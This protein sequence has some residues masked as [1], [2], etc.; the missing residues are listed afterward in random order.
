MVKHIRMLPTVD[1]LEGLML[2]G[3]VSKIGFTG[4]LSVGKPKISD[5]QYMDMVK[6]AVA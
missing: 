3:A 6:G 2:L 4:V 1:F 5:E